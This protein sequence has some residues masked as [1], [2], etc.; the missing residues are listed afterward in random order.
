MQNYHRNLYIYNLYD[1]QTDSIYFLS[2]LALIIDQTNLLTLNI[3]A[4]LKVATRWGLQC[5]SLQDN[6]I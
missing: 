5:T 2:I 6:H 3:G 1:L 4:I